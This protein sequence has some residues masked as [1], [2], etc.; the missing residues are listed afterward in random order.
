VTTFKCEKCKLI[1][2][3]ENELKTLT[4]EIHG[5]IFD[6]DNDVME[7]RKRIL[8]KLDEMEEIDKVLKVFVDQSENFMMLTM[9]DGTV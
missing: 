5:N 4:T 7:A 1:S 3:N 8:E 2:E 6:W 9:L